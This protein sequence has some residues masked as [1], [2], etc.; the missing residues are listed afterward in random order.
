VR[1]GRLPPNRD[2]RIL[3]KPQKEEFMRQVLFIL[4]GVWTVGLASAQTVVTVS[5]NRIPATPN[6]V[7][8]SV[9]V[10]YPTQDLVDALG[11]VPG[12]V[13]HNEGGGAFLSPTGFGENGFARLTILVDG[14]P[15]NNPDMAPPDLNAIPWQDVEHVEVYSNSVWWGGLGTV[16]NVITKKPAERLSGTLAASVDNRLGHT[17]YARL[18]V[19][20]GKNFV[21]TLEA[22]NNRTVSTQASNSSWSPSAGLSLAWSG[23]DFS[24]VLRLD[25]ARELYDL[26]GSLTQA[27]FEANPNQAGSYGSLDNTLVENRASL[28]TRGKA[29]GGD[30]DLPLGFFSRR[31]D[32]F[33]STLLTQG[34]AGF[35]EEWL[36][37]VGES[38]YASIQGGLDESESAYLNHSQT[39]SAAG[40]GLTW[41]WAKDAFLVQV[42]ARPQVF[43]N[44]GQVRT[45]LPL[46]GSLIG[47]LGIWHAKLTAAQTVREPLL[48]EEFNLYGS[49]YFAE[50]PNLEPE[51]GKLLD[52]SLEADLGNL[53]LKVAPTYLWLANE[54]TYVTNASFIGQNVNLSGTSTHATWVTSASYKLT[55]WVHAQA[56]YTFTD[57]RD[58][59]GNALPLV[60]A[61]TVRLGLDSAWGG[62]DWS[63]FSPYDAFGSTASVGS[64]YLLDAYLQYSFRNG[65]K[66]KASVWNLLDDR[67]PSEV[68]Y[69]GWYPTEGR[70]LSFE[71]SWRF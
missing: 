26:P 70:T 61:H 10:V 44:D 29:F 45:D 65:L 15:Y 53:T 68:Y 48:D 5:A 27:Q 49:A 51:Q 1:F 56:S 41:S 34:S 30:F 23:N 11:Q 24:S 17:E 57:A 36:V 6:T 38:D 55:S 3:E 39:T 9:T 13:I 67:T 46:S 40:L 58:S 60:S 7:G 64:R 71:A 22:A 12:L 28:L 16:I 43:T 4:L 2:S 33:A 42:T 21:L 25:Y 19:P 69:N 31:V 50:N 18:N 14:I 54:I 35:H 63:W 62:A 37:P 47:N 66:L 8:A 20:S 59:S 52:A 32:A